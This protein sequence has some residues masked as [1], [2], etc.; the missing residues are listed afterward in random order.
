MQHGAAKALRGAC[1]EV[2]QSRVR[3]VPEFKWH[4]HWGRQRSISIFYVATKSGSCPPPNDNN[5]NNNN[6]ALII[7]VRVIYHVVSQVACYPV[8]IFFV[9][10]FSFLMLVCKIPTLAAFALF[11]YLTPLPSSA[12]S[13][14]FSFLF[15]SSPL[16]QAFRPHDF[17][18][19][20]LSIKSS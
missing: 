6:L 17:K 14:G 16:L 8:S 3:C 13:C 18:H 12:I 20:E 7:E 5:N 15:P 10:S 1:L 9:I 19:Y 11:A 4:Q 2:S